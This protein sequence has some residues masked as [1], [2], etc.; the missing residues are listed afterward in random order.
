MTEHTWEAN[1]PRP[2]PDCVRFADWLPLLTTS[3]PLADAQHDVVGL[4]G[5]KPLG[6]DGMNALRA[7]V[8]RCA[9]CQAQ[10]ATYEA[11]ENALRRAYAVPTGVAPF[12]SFQS[13]ASR[14]A[15][16][17]AQPDLDER[18]TPDV[19]AAPHMVE[20]FDTPTIRS[21]KEVRMTPNYEQENPFDT[22]RG[23]QGAPGSYMQDDSGYIAVAPSAR[24]PQAHPRRRLI[25][26]VSALAAAVLIV[27]LF[28]ALFYT[29]GGKNHHLSTGPATR[30]LGANGHWQVVNRFPFKSGTNATGY[31]VAPSNVQV[32]YRT[33]GSDG[34]KMQ[35]SDDGGQTW[36]TISLPTR[37]FPAGFPLNGYIHI[38]PLDPHIIILTESSD[39]SNPNCP[40]S[41]LG[42]AMTLGH[43]RQLSAETPSSGGYSC[44]FQYS[45]RDG[46]AHWTHL[47]LVDNVKLSVYFSSSLQVAGTRLFAFAQP[48]VN[49]EASQVGRLMGSAD[50]G[51]TWQPVDSAIAAQG[52]AVEDSQFVA[53]PTGSTLFTVS[54]PATAKSGDGQAYTP[55]LWRS[56]DDGAH[57]TNEGVFNTPPAQPNVSGAEY[58]LLAA[59]SAN[60]QVALYEMKFGYLPYATPT[61]TG[62]G[63]PLPPPFA[64]GAGAPG[65]VFV[66]VDN[67]HS[68]Q[69]A[70]QKGVPSGLDMPVFSMGVTGTLSD[71]SIVMLFDKTIVKTET[72]QNGASYT[73][74]MQDAAYYAWAPGQNTWQQLTPSYNADNVLQQ[75]ITLANGSQPET[76]WQIVKQGNT[77]I[78]EKCALTD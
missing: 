76:V 18:A 67:G 6:E 35:R 55:Y 33:I 77:A 40:A 78:L 53:T 61:P 1:I 73:V 2:G 20:T 31:V 68:W 75:W 50:G 22:Q 30:Y 24:R 11:T 8:A 4:N 62:N 48:D 19:P 16:F 38:S 39:Q 23:P 28:G 32:I 69:E 70:A 54:L 65:D 34:A 60:G 29:L 66:S 51:F 17:D 13:I 74:T 12:L 52:Q 56:D 72:L 7:H 43:A 3:T 37:Y 57:W 46:G 47:S 58:N 42:G 59:S 27:A 26:G 71:G 41:N 9:S 36:T 45:S 25:Q 44:T 10:L 63:A 64:P 15:A 5:S 14:V 21:E 49:G